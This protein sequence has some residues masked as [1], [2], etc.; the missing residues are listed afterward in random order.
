MSYSFTYAN[1]NL[2]I[3]HLC[4]VIITLSNQR[5]LIWSKVENIINIWQRLW[6]F[7][8]QMSLQWVETN[9]S[10]IRFFPT[11]ICFYLASWHYANS[12]QMS[13]YRYTD[14]RWVGF[15]PPVSL[16][17]YSK[18][19]SHCSV[20]CA[21]LRIQKQNFIRILVVTNFVYRRTG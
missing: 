4:T 9:P 8:R 11:D 16:S 1:D 18:D 21:T 6:N 7:D 2:N 14:V 20:F 5:C 15:L 12:L 3:R 10:I 17:L 19:C 13:I